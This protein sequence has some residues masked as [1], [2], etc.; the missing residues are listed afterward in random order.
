MLHEKI[1]L[2]FILVLVIIS[3]HQVISTCTVGQKD[4]IL[5]H[6]EK[7]IKVGRQVPK[8]IPILGQACC[9]AVNRVPREG[10][11]INIQCIVDEL[12]P[13]DREKNDETKILNLPNH[14]QETGTCTVE[15]KDAILRHCEKFVKIGRQMPKLI[16]I[17]G[18]ACCNAVNRVPRKG[19]DI[20]IQCI[21]DKLTRT[22]R[23]KNDENKIINLP[24][25]C[26]EDAL[27]KV[28]ID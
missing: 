27:L 11:D 19:K 9:N 26:Q 1:A 12:T 2:L 25:H 17:Q 10:K 8:P 20:D 13:T 6:C 7:F 22:D 23:E 15:Q 21:V 18:Q 4:A 16:P 28:R 5:H 24:N 14:C 3:A